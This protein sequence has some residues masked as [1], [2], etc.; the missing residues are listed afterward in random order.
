M[1]YLDLAREGNLAVVHMRHGDEN[2]FTTP[3]LTE[4]IDTLTMLEDDPGT[5]GVVLT[6]QQEKFFSTGIDLE[7][8]MTV[9]GEDPGKVTEFLLLLNRTLELC[10]GYKKPFVAALN[11][12]AVGG[13]AILAA[14]A[15]FRL[16]NSERGFVRLPE[17]NVDIP[18][19]PGMIA[20]FRDI[21]PPKSFRDMALTGGRYTGEQALAMGFVD[22]LVK[23][24][25]LV[26]RALE[27][28]S[29]LAGAKTE[30]YARIKRDL[31]QHVL[32]VMH[33]EDAREATMLGKIF[34]ERT[35]V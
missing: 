27:F 10:T 20:L 4:L 34:R 9:G 15:D 29:S 35:G 19:W 16:M 13:G 14:C 24:G 1:E 6:A 22:E 5:R 31:R 11:G 2:R 28:T 3:F 25:N 8:M 12:H 7:W 23:P 30:T 26:M 18:F 21:L 17:V 33:E 32:K